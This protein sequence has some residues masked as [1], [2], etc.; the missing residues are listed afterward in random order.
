MRTDT[1][2]IGGGIVGL[3]AGYFLSRV[4]P[5][6]SV[7]IIEKES[8]V[9]KHQTGHNS[10]V[11]H[12][13]IYYKPNSY[14]AR[15][16][17]RGKQ[18]M[19]QFCLANNIKFDIC[20][21]II[22][23][24]RDAELKALQM[25]HERGQ[26]NGVRC[27]V[28]SPEELQELEPH[29]RGIRG[30]IVPDAGIIDFVGVANKL[31]EKIQVAGGKVLTGTKLLGARRS[32]ELSVLSTTKGDIEA[33]L[34]INCAGLHSDRVARLLGA[35]PK[36]KIIPFRGEYFKLK[37]ASKRLCRNL[38]YPVPNPDFPFLG[39]HYTRMIS[40]EVECGPNAVLAFARE[41]YRKTSFNLSDLSE[42]LTYPG[43]LRFIAPHLGMG[44]AEMWRSL[45]KAA[46]VSSLQRLIPEVSGADLESAPAGVRAQA[47]SDDGKFVDD[48]VI[49]KSP[50]V[51]NVLNAPSPAATS[52]LSLAEYIVSQAAEQVSW[53]Q[54]DGAILSAMR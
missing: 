43:F 47:I 21:K 9:A 44:L 3:A 42:T 54:R 26:A 37:G 19:E 13:G 8:A 28:V 39:V 50:G 5:D 6:R 14:K 32:N 11:L 31:A 30:L 36:V 10:G 46:F 51:I 45:N 17:V 27:S 7:T 24:T 16:C 15:N 18:L 29:V 34:V 33:T 1:A 35:S 4:Y 52:S 12:T 48:F 53:Q 25:I 40:G 49:E 2:I 23:A 41:G 38:I 20:G 22:V